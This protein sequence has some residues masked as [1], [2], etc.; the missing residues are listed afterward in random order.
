MRGARGAG[1]GGWAW[2]A[3]GTVAL[4]ACAPAVGL[5]PAP[6]VA[7]PVPETAVVEVPEGTVAEEPAPEVADPEP[8]TSMEPGTPYDCDGIRPARVRW[9]FRVSTVTADLVAVV[10]PEEPQAL[11]PTEQLSAALARA[12]AMDPGAT[13]TFERIVLQNTA[14]SAAVRASGTDAAT[15]AAVARRFALPAEELEALGTAPSSE[16]DLWIGPRKGWIDRKGETCG[17]GRLLFHDRYFHGLRAFRPIRTG[18]RRALVSQLVAL[19]TEGKPH[20][21][22]VIGEIE[23]RRGLGPGAAACVVE[24]AA[25]TL[26]SG[27]A[28]GLRAMDVTELGANRFV[29]RVGARR[30]GCIGC[31]EGSGIGDFADVAV[32]ERETLRANRD[33]ASVKA[34]EE[35]TAPLF[36]PLR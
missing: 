12:S 19:D 1:R 31:H 3:A 15:A 9:P 23:L 18:S 28:D 33:A 36:A 34:A 24:L 16:L 35:A 29:H 7:V 5:A 32:E 8:E 27:V 21:T 14:L 6:H 25:D 22:P 26:R 17:D 13:S 10:H 30:V 4:A 11:A 2:V 20:I